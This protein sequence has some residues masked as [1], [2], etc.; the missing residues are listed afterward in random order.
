MG[1]G[2]LLIFPKPGTQRLGS[3]HNH[4][5]VWVQAHPPC[6]CPHLAQHPAE[7]R[8][9]GVHFSCGVGGCVSGQDR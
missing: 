6:L 5:S 1:K 7:T 9:A 3:L 4:P 2:D 8:V